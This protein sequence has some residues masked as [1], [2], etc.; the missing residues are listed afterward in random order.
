MFCGIYIASIRS[1]IAS[2]D[3]IH[4]IYSI[5]HYSTTLRPRCKF[6]YLT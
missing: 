2:G 5:L 6:W 1:P 3:A 4:A